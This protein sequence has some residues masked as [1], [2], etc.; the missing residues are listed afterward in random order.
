MPSGNKNIAKAG[1]KTQF[2]KTNPPKNPGRKRKLVSTIIDDLK[3]EGF[4]SAS[5]ENIRRLY[6]TFLNLTE[7]KLRE[8]F[9][10]SEQPILVK[11]L[12]KSVLSDKSF[13]V[14]ETIIDRAH[15]KAVQVAKVEHSG[16]IT[17]FNVGFKK[18]EDS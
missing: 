14:I 18:D 12:V 1:K 11:I 15:G 5:P 16:E 7:D 2:S 3:K 8:L 4:D 10:D 13:E 6:E 17:S 9:A